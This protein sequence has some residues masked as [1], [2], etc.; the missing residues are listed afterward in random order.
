MNPDVHAS[1]GST[2]QHLVT[3]AARTELETTSIQQMIS[4]YEHTL[5]LDSEGRLYACGINTDGQC[6]TGSDEDQ[7]TFNKIEV[8][9]QVQE[10]GIRCVRAGADTSA[11]ITDAG[12]LWTFGNSEY[13]QAFHGEKIDR[14]LSPL[15]VNNASL[16]GHKVQD[17]QTAGSS[18]VLLD[19]ESFR[20]YAVPPSMSCN[21]R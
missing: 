7:Y 4:G 12:G 6:G 13:G 8:P 2:S 1:R 14:V 9:K 15:L 11:I 17:F 18:S 21:T 16:Q 19:G 10:E 20:N 5:A 3:R